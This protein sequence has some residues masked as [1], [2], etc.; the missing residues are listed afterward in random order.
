MEWAVI[1]H[2]MIIHHL[3]Y[4]VELMEMEQ[5]NQSIVKQNA[6]EIENEESQILLMNPAQNIRL[7]KK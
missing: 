7:P 6:T 3:K 1:L 4:D 5:E 2:N